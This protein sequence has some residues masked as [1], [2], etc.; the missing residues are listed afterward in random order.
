MYGWRGVVK[1]FST[2]LVPES[3]PRNNAE[4]SLTLRKPV[5]VPYPPNNARNV[6]SLSCSRHRYVYICICT[7]HRA[8]VST[9]AR[10][11]PSLFFPPSFPF[12]ILCSPSNVS[13]TSSRLPRISDIAPYFPSL[14]LEISVKIRTFERT[15]RKLHYLATLFINFNN[16]ESATS[17]SKATHTRC[18]AKQLFGCTRIACSRPRDGPWKPRVHGIRFRALSRP[19]LQTC[20]YSVLCSDG[21]GGRAKRC[22]ESKGNVVIVGTAFDGRYV[23]WP[24]CTDTDAITTRASLSLSLSFAR[25]NQSFKKFYIGFI[26]CDFF[27]RSRRVVS[28]S[29]P[30]FIHRL[31]GCWR[32]RAG[33]RFIERFNGRSPANL[34]LS[35]VNQ[36]IAL[37]LVSKEV[38]KMFIS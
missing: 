31:L 11:F 8:T 4:R 12:F 18:R 9:V 22:S 6:F 15:T 20:T 23:R 29:R 38:P 14:T 16:V 3:E 5:L 27:E 1:R 34:N 7:Y 37:T 24:R 33:T 25:A 36:R 19:V 35:R 32:E 10:R 21:D 28:T 17:A 30:R 26:Q 2:L 13:R